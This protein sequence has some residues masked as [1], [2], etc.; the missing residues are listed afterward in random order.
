[1]EMEIILYKY[2]IKFCFINVTYSMIH[3]DWIKTSCCPPK[4]IYYFTV[5]LIYVAK[6]I[7]PQGNI[8]PQRSWRKWL[9]LIFYDI[10]K[11]KKVSPLPSF[12]L[13]SNRQRRLN[14][15][16]MSYIASCNLSDLSWH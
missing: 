15:I 9:F 12:P 2:S 3:R 14:L 5:Y 11:D 1:M 16:S 7:Q 13:F 6:N 4:N 8:Q 10:F